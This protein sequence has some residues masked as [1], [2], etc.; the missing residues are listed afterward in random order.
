M[1]CTLQHCLYQNSYLFTLLSKALSINIQGITVGTLSLPIIDVQ[2]L[3][4]LRD[5]V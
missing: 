2:S 5:F 4:L 1:Q 3:C